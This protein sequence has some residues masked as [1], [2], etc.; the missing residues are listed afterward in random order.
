MAVFT[1]PPFSIVLAIVDLI[2]AI[3]FSKSSGMLSAHIPHGISG[4]E[5]GGA[6]SWQVSNGSLSFFALGAKDNES[7]W[8][9]FQV[10]DSF[11]KTW[12]YGIGMA[13]VS[14]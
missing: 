6:E 13:Y 12:Q 14:R 11:V 2:I 9:P 10:C 3:F 1:P 7:E 5:K 4:C 8:T